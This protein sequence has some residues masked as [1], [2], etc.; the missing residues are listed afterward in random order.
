[1]TTLPTLWRTVLRAVEILR[2]EG[3]VF[4]APPRHLPQPRQQVVAASLLLLGTTWGPHGI[5]AAEQPAGGYPSCA[6]G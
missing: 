2:D 6:T 4:T 3:L 1:M 5:H